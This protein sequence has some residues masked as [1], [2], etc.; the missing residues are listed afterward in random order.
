M[1]QQ[2]KELAEV[3]RAYHQKGWSPATSTNYSFRLADRPEVI[4]VSRSGIDKSLFSASDFMEVDMQGQA[5]P[6]YEGIR[7]S[8]ET[9]IHCKLYQL[10]PEMMCI[11]HSHS[12]Y[13]VLQSM[14]KAQSVELSGYEVLKG[15]EGIKTHETTVQVPVFDNTQDM[16]AFAAVLEAEKNRLTVP[17]F[18]MRQHGTYA[19]GRNLFEAKRHL[20]TAEYLFEVDWKFS[21]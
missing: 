11:V 8:A 17:A 12:V 15:F 18:I 21:N 10:F 1:E 16:P 19:W 3:I 6:A 2:K 14:K 9:L 20:E 5:L 13:S 4:V 7:P